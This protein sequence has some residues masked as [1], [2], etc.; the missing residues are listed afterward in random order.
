MRCC[1]VLCGAGENGMLTPRY[2]EAGPA[3]CGLPHGGRPG[4]RGVGRRDEGAGDPVGGGVAEL[5][6]EHAHGPLG[7]RGHLGD[8]GLGLGL[9]IGSG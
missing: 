5:P 9:G 6:E 4:R 7:T 1:A 2:L 8:L 3:P